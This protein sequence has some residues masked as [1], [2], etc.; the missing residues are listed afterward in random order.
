[1]STPK[2]VVLHLGDDI[3]FNPE[4]YRH[5]AESFTVIQPSLADRQREVWLQ[6]LRDR[7]WGDFEAVFRPFW[8]SGLEMGR[9][10]AEMIPLLPASLKVFASAGAGYDWAD[11]D[12]LA[13]AGILYCNGASASSEAVADM[14]I[15]HIISVFRN[16][17]FSNMA[18]RSGDPS[19]FLDAHRNQPTGAR[20]PAGHVLGV[21][22]LGNIGFRIAT[23]AR[24]CFG[25]RILYN[26]PVPRPAED[27]ASLDAVRVMELDDLLAQVDCVVIAAPGTAG[28]GLINAGRIAKMKRGARL[29]NVARG[30]LVDEEA[31]ADALEDGHLHAVGLDVFEDEPNVSPRLARH[32]RATLTAHNGGGA[33]ETTSGF[34][35]LAMQNVQ[36][37]LEGRPALTPVN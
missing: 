5:L 35:A 32:P 4:I 30:C 34:E 25:M 10:D 19:A 29:V 28:R 17:Q 7:K 36:A 6:N 3:E 37:V 24:A 14:A 15:Y 27:E 16:L 9:W 11:V 26:D 33:F 12:L 18:A 20:N 22:G 13:E 8:N 2:P 31:L 23:K 21:V 1:M